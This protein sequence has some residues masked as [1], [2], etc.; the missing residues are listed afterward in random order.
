VNTIAQDLLARGGAQST[1]ARAEAEE[2]VA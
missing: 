1:Y 2:A